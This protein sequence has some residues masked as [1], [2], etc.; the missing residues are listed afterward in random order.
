MLTWP[1]GNGPDSI[2][3]DGGDATLLIHMGTEYEAAGVV[4]QPDTAVLRNLKNMVDQAGVGL[5][6]LTLFG[7]VST[8]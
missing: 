1:D 6:N 4:P 2:V 5:P 3:D 8:E 7:E